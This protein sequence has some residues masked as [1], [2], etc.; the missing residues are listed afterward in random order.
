M[1]EMASLQATVRGRV[2]GVFFRAFVVERA[3]QM[4]L[5]GYVRNRPGGVVEVNAEGEKSDL[6]KLAGYLKTGPPGAR[7][8]EVKIGWAEYTGHYSNFKVR[9]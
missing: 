2:Q 5:M 6:E 4:N 8:D 1:A 7:V 3:E 9:Y